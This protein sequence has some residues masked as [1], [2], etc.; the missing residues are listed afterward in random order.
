MAGRIL[1]RQKARKAKAAEVNI[2]YA[3]PIILNSYIDLT[4]LTANY[5]DG[6][7]PAGHEIDR[8]RQRWLLRLYCKSRDQFCIQLRQSVDAHR[9]TATLAGRTRHDN[10][11]SH[12]TI[13]ESGW[14]HFLT[15]HLMKNPFG[16]YTIKYAAK[17]NQQRALMTFLICKQLWPGFALQSAQD[18]NELT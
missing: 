4:N 9:T 14:G 15:N 2:C 10:L 5:K 16:N 11:Q 18:N 7:E 17:Q 3:C 6:A 13:L 12:G 8:V 1:E